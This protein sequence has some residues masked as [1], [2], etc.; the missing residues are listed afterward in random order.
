MNKLLSLILLACMLVNLGG[1][2]EALNAEER[3]FLASELRAW[4]E[5]GGVQVRNLPQERRFADMVERTLR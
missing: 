5:E 1:R 2:S 4:L 3:Q